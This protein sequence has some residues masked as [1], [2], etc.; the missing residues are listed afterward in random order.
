MLDRPTAVAYA[1]WFACLSDPTRL[2]LLHELATAEGSRSVG[3]LVDALGVAQ[4]TV[5][6]HLRRLAELEFV[7]VERVGTTSRVR[8][9]PD[10]LAAFPTAAEI[11]MARVPVQVADSRTGSRTGSRAGSVPWRQQPDQ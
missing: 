2:Q 10:C 5:S 11:V 8:V 7:F 3:Q 6:A 9:N 1:S 4:S